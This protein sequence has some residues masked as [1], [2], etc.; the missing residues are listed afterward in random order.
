M[1]DAPLLLKRARETGGEVSGQI[2]GKFGVGVAI[3]L[4]DEIEEISVAFDLRT[5]DNRRSIPAILAALEANGEWEHADEMPSRPLQSYESAYSN[6][7][8]RE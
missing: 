1:I 2:G 8:I 7:C 3:E 4:A 5:L 6:T